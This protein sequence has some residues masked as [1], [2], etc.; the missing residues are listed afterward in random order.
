VPNREFLNFQALLCLMLKFSIPNAKSAVTQS[1]T[2]LSY[3]SLPNS[4]LL[5]S[6]EVSQ[7]RVLSEHSLRALYN[8]FTL[9]SGKML[10][11]L[12]A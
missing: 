6:D 5:F 10:Q 12:C 3:S 11:R 7:K 4:K 8:A 9:A 1:Q 2:I